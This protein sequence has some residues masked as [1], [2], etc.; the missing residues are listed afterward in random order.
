MA[1]CIRIP[2]MTAAPSPGVG[3]NPSTC[4]PLIEVTQMKGDGEAHPF[5]SPN[6]EFAD[7]E[8]WD[9]GNLNL[10]V[11]KT[12]E[13][14]QFEYARSALSSACSWRRTWR[15]PYQGRHDRLQRCPHGY[16]RPGGGQLL[17]KLRISSPPITAPGHSC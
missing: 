9:Q 8:T 7:F 5:L 10:S 13:M 3:R 11:A 14:L 2:S 16:G 4:E 12:N 6:D 1:G 15:Q 17:R